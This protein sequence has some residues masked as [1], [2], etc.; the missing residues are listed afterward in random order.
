MSVRVRTGSS[1]TTLG[2]AAAIAA[3]TTLTVSYVPPLQ[4]ALLSNG[5]TC[6]VRR[7]TGW[8]C[9]LCGMTH[10][11]VALLRGDV[12]ES[13]HWNP[14]A[15]VFVV[16]IAIALGVTASGTFRV[17]MVRMREALPRHIGLLI[18][19]SWLAFTVIRNVP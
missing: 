10:G 19:V 11:V 9:P 7:T 17:S 4:R 8:K 13:L 1:D 3:A 5:V 15:T 6:L 12:L 2:V 16:A 14:F 18:P